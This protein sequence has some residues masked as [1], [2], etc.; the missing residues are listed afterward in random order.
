MGWRYAS[1]AF[2]DGED[3]DADFDYG[4]ARILDGI[5]DFIRA[6]RSKRVRPRT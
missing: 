4:L 5:E 2:D 3:L 1:G 6:S